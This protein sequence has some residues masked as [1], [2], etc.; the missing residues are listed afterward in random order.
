MP[1]PANAKEIY[2]WLTSHGYSDNAAA[3]ILGNMEQESGGNPESAGS[4]GNGLIGF[5][6]ARA[7]IVTGNVQADLLKQLKDVVAYDNANGNVSSLNKSSSPA[8]AAIDYMK[9]FERPAVA[10]ENEVNRVSSAQAVAAAAQSGNWSGSSSTLDSNNTD[11]SL[12]SDIFGS[13]GTDLIN[14]VLGAF[15]V[16]SLSDLLERAGLVLLGLVLILIGIIKVTG[17]PSASAKNKVSSSFGG[18]GE[19]DDDS[20]DYSD[21]PYKSEAGKRQYENWQDRE[22]EKAYNKKARS[23]DREDFRTSG[24]SGAVGGAKSAV[25]KSGVIKDL[26]KEVAMG[27]EVVPF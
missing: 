14:G 10:T 17:G 6:P 5:T 24:T 16:Q 3:G 22:T 15:G 19:D 1:L 27:A 9:V 12:G 7:G 26:G 25:K 23:V 18:G 20:E 4:G 11:A 13:I 21:K 8:A 2:E